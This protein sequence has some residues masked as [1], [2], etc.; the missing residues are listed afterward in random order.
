VEEFSDLDHIEK[1]LAVRSAHSI[2]EMRAQMKNNKQPKKVQENELFALDINHIVRL[3]LIYLS[4]RLAR[5]KIASN[6][7]RDAKIRTYLEAGVK[8][9]ALK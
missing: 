8:I 9:F 2:R 1:A 5:E 6:T 7:F 3:H 4:F